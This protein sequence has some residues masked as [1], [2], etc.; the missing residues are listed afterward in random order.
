MY[1]ITSLNGTKVMIEE[2]HA[3]YTEAQ[4]ALAMFVDNRKAE[5]E[6]GTD[7]DS[8][9]GYYSSIKNS[10]YDSMIEELGGTKSVSTWQG[11]IVS[12]NIPDGPIEIHY[13][14]FDESLNYAVGVVGN[15]D[16]A[17]YKTYTTPEVDELW[18][19]DAGYMVRNEALTI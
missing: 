9:T 6:D 5:Y 17:T 19:K 4:V 15:K 2:D 3:A 8:D 18:N 16:L 11:S 13:T 7:K 14:A 12:R 10:D 1:E